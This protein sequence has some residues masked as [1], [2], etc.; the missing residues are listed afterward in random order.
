[1]LL[2]RKKYVDIIVY[3]KNNAIQGMVSDR[4]GLRAMIVDYDKEKG[5]CIVHRPFVPIE[6][7]PEFFT[8]TMAGDEL[9]EEL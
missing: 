4:Q 1:M 5:N 6:Y 8:A 9:E 7:N 3:V 2:M